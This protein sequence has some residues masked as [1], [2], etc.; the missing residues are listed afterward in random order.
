MKPEILSF[1]VAALVALIGASVAVAR[2]FRKLEVR[3]SSVETKVDGLTEAVNKE[4]QTLSGEFKTLDTRVRTHV[5]DQT[6]H[7]T[8]AWLDETA[9]HRKEMLGMM[10]KFD[11]RLYEHLKDSKR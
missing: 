3:L 8:P 1:I 7:I 9:S 5:T 10:H 4:T 6:C 2:Y 11:E